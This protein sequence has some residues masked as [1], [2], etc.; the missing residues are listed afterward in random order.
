LA[1]WLFAAARETH[2]GRALTGTIT[3]AQ[4]SCRDDAIG[5]ELDFEDSCSVTA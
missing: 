4:L 5:L 3:A 2:A 1:R